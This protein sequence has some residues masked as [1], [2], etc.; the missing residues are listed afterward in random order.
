MSKKGGK[1]KSRSKEVFTHF[2]IYILS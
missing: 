2:C 1:T